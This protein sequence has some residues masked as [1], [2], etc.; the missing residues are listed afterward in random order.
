MAEAAHARKSQPNSASG[1]R[2]PLP[3]LLLVAAQT[4]GPT[5]TANGSFTNW[6]HKWWQLR[7][8]SNPV[9]AEYLTFSSYENM[10][11]SNS[12]KVLRGIKKVRSKDFSNIPLPKIKIWLVPWVV[13]FL[14][15]K[16]WICFYTHL[17]PLSHET[18]LSSFYSSTWRLPEKIRH[19]SGLFFPSAKRLGG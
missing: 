12:K 10:M 18:C 9:R 14:H 2:D 4:P 7:V 16:S 6:A 1:Q 11:F 5:M 8:V 17:I 15:Q 13:M 3:L 19:P